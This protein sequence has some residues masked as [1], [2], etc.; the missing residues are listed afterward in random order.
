MRFVEVDLFGVYVA[1][2]SLMLIG[3]WVVTVALRRM[4][5]RFGLLQHV[6]HPALFVFAVYVIV[7]S[8]IV[9]T[10]AW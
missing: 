2:M 4:V 10:V 5:V 1:P 3:A 9:L 6:W 8:L 7:L